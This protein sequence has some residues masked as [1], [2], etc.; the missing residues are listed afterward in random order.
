MENLKLKNQIIEVILAIRMLLTDNVPKIVK[1]KDISEFPGISG[2]KELLADLNPLFIE[3]H[4]NAEKIIE[5]IKTGIDTYALDY[6]SAPGIIIID[7]FGMLGT[8]DSSFEAENLMIKAKAL[9]SKKNTSSKGE[10]GKNHKGKVN[11]KIFIVTG[12]AQGFGCG[13]VENLFNEGA[14]LVIADINEEKG[15]ELSSKLNNLNRKNKAIFVK[16]DVTDPG[17]VEDLIFSTVISF[18]G[19]DAII[20]NAGVL[21]AGSLEDMEPDVFEKVTKVNYIGYYHCAKY[22]SVIFKVQNKYK[23]GYFT[24]IIQINSKSGLKGSNKNFAYAG[25]KFGGIGLTQSFALELMEYAIKVNSI[26]PGNFFEGPLWSDPDNGL[27][28]QYLKA[29]KVAGAKTIGDVRKYYE[30]QVPAGRGCKVEDVM[31][32]IYYVIEQEYETGQAIPVTG[33]QIM[34]R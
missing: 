8:G 23:K 22:A 5:N 20:S 32:A 34:I 9:L 18:G 16:T 33:G 17:S 29:G 7:K 24:D 14:N 3:K 1:Y 31:K 28:V 13:I 4:D 11:S 30:K 6:N 27:F 25:G 19:L 26:C 12:G 15:K 10:P 21:M 2:K